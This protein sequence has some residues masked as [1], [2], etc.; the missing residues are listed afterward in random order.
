MGTVTNTRY[1]RHNLYLGTG[2]TW[3]VY[4]QMYM[5]SVVGLR[6]SVWV[7]NGDNL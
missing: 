7:P 2:P 4:R 1:V 5:G 6:M 3:T